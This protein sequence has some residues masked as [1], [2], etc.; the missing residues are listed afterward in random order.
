MVRMYGHVSEHSALWFILALSSLNFC[1]TQL[2]SASL[3][4]RL[5][6]AFERRSHDELGGRRNEVSF[7]LSMK[8]DVM[9]GDITQ[10]AQ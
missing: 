10:M 1:H 6:T 4:W 7:P 3:L 5:H 2:I 9:K 8:N